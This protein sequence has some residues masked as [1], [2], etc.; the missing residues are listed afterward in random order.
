MTDPASPRPFWRR[1]LI[2]IVKLVVGG[3]ILWFVA[4]QLTID[5]EIGLSAGA[6]G[7]VVSGRELDWS[8]Q[9][10]LTTDDGTVH[11]Y[12]LRSAAPEI[13][14]N[15]GRWRF[16]LADGSTIEGP[17]VTCD[18]KAVLQT[19]AGSRTISLAD[20]GWREGGKDNGWVER[21]PNIREG[22]ATIFGSISAG[23]YLLALGSILS[24][25]LCGIK[26]WQ[27]LLRAQDIQ[28]TFFE[29][30][31]LT[32]IGFFFNNAVP[33]LTG[34]DV[35]KAVMIARA[36][37][38]RGPDAVS[39]VIVDR[40]VGLLVLAAM[41]A[42]VLL[43]SFSSYRTI[44]V[45]VFLMLG[46][47]AFAICLFMSRRIRKLLRIDKLLS[48]LPGSDALKRL[49]KA[50]LLY[51]RRRK[52]MAF[53]IAISL[54]SHVFNVLSVWFIGQ[55]LGVDAAHGLKEPALLTYFVVVPIIMI[56]SA[57]P[58]LPGG[59]GVGEAAFGYFFRSVGIRN[60]TLAVGLSVLLRVS[61]LGW[62][63]VGGVFLFLSR[64][65]ARAA[66]HDAQEL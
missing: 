20:V 23:H 37:Q 48:M 14:F 2:T 39:T 3:L 6:G 55:D 44:A 10:S 51:R 32:F 24:M 57:V 26:R 58:V 9:V 16:H 38:G 29:A 62:S 21:T 33:G 50:F 15:H 18:G 12:D 45:W 63:L 19:D 49:D 46:G 36:H 53:C 35:V 7:G 65:E 47:A 66:I 56:V 5:D 64:K 59:W 60:L 8:G 25:Y 27:V 41:A 13:R 40:V 61:M 22:L 30:M 1:H 31:R 42:G 28:V 17:T 11:T 43:F 34:G 54:L 4:S 52:E